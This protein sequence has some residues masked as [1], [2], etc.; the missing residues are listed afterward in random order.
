MRGALAFL[1][2][3]ACRDDQAVT[4]TLAESMTYIRSGQPDSR[5]LASHALVLALPPLCVHIRSQTITF[6]K[7][8]N[9]S[10]TGQA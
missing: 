5:T 10:I 8:C 1:A 2:S 3:A 7:I 4:R 9:R 6:W